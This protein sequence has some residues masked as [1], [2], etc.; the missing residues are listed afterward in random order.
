M[1]ELTYA[2]VGMNAVGGIL[3]AHL[4]SAQKRTILVHAN[5]DE[6]A[7]I[8]RR[9]LLI[10]GEVTLAV[11][12]SRLIPAI[13]RLSA[14]KPDVVFLCTR[15]SIQE[16]IANQ[17]AE[18][19]PKDCVVVSM[20]MGLDSEEPLNRVLG[21]DRVVR[22]IA[23]FAGYNDEPAVYSMF[24]TP[25]PTYLG[26]AT[27][28]AQAHAD[29]LAPMLNDIGLPAQA[30]D[31]IRH[32]VWHQAIY[33]SPIS[34]ICALTGLTAY[35]ASVEPHAERLLRYILR[36]GLAVAQ[37]DGYSF[38][39]QATETFLHMYRGGDPYP[40]EMRQALELGQQTEVEYLHGRIMELG[41][42]HRIATPL[43]YTF[44]QLIKAAEARPL[45]EERVWLDPTHPTMPATPRSTGAVTVDALTP[46]KPT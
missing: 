1:P 34:G 39:D 12:V 42:K 4:L 31:T 30:T 8:R 20:Q 23:G 10:A 15:T 3:A 29:K 35:Q 28:A 17:L 21:E 32:H 43:H 16:P 44:Y 6:L 11:E 7:V 40:H 27:P 37:A 13:N 2:V 41:Q 45:T 25:F 22:G 36:E 5:R 26:G 33:A 24:H 46:K 9:G 14:L 38:G 19:L 18:N